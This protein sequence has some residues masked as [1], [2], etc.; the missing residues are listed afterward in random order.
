MICSELTERRSVCD[1]CSD[2]GMQNCLFQGMKEQE[3]QSHCLI[4]A[5]IVGCKTACFKTL[6][7]N[8]KIFI[9]SVFRSWDAK[10]PASRRSA[11]TPRSSS[12]M[13]SDRGMQ[14]SLK[15]HEHHIH[16][17]DH[18]KRPLFLH[19]DEV[20]RW[21]SIVYF[22]QLLSQFIPLVF[23]IANTSPKGFRSHVVGI[24]SIFP[25]TL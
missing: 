24:C 12:D 14:N 2:R 9:W 25:R 18:A 5:Q 11:R 13:C 17:P 21:N 3:R 6:S 7:K 20:S 10:R 16:G 22:C 15:E 1:M 19:T 4:C 8:A 23:M